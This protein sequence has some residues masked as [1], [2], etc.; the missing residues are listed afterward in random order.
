MAK[1]A[2]TK[3]W[4]TYLPAYVPTYTTRCHCLRTAKA[5]RNVTST[6]QQPR[7]KQASAAAHDTT[8]AT[9]L[10]SRVDLLG[11]SLVPWGF[12]Q[13]ATGRAVIDEGF[14][15]GSTCLYVRMSMCMPIAAVHISIHMPI[16]MPVHMPVHMSIHM[17]IR[18]AVQPACSRYLFPRLSPGGVYVVEDLSVAYHYAIV[19]G[20]TATRGTHVALRR[21]RGAKDN[22]VD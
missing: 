17:S 11:W 19:Q 3:V 10:M 12:D 8:I 4:G 13:S 1:D 16:H 15:V 7:P 20:P 2:G 18:M 21:R 9:R 22:G 6:T 14:P 5:S